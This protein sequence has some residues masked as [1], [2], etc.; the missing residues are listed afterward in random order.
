MNVLFKDLFGLF[1]FTED[2]YARIRKILVPPQAYAWQ[3]LI[4]LSVFSGFLSYFATGYIRDTIAFFGWLFLIA[5]TAWYTTD[6]PV[7][8]PG[9][10]MPVGAVITGF[11]V[12][13]FA[14]GNQQDVIT[15]RT[16][17][18]WPTISALITAIP[19]FIEGNDT[20]SK[21]QIPKP[22]ARQRIII[23]VGSCMLLSCWLQFYYVTDKW[24][25]EYPSLLSENFQRS[26]FVRRT[27]IVTEKVPRNGVLILDKLQ[28]IVEQQIDGKPWSQVE[29][30]LKDV[31][32]NVTNLGRGVIEKNLGAYEE[33][34]LWRVEPRVDNIKS[35]GYKLD[36]LSIWLGP[37]ARKQGYY[38]IKTCRI[39]PIAISTKQRITNANPE[40]KIAVGEIQ[41]DRV[42]RF[43]AS[44]PPPRR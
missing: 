14:F 9:T 8:V 21:A 42:T 4:Y 25:T 7:R 32:V 11:L 27:D 6:D 43:V 19:E 3:T 2:I 17:V 29:K 31:D 12:S 26:A 44:L 41:C 33:K 1:K 28:P 30:W 22:E 20:S 37:T 10:Y 36:L 5:G 16:I 24:L 40:D 18:L 15:P 38:F 39:D 34:A 23:L 13:V 35:T